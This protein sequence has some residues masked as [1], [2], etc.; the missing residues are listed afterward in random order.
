[1]ATIATN[2]DPQ[3]QSSLSVMQTLVDGYG[4]RDFAVRFWDGTTWSPDSG[5]AASFTLVLNHPGSVRRMFWPPRP[6]TTGQAFLYD[7]FDVEGDMLA[8]AGLCGFLAN[9]KNR[10]SLLQKLRLGWRIWKLPEVIKPRL[11]REAVKLT[12][13]KHSRQRDHQAISYHYDTP[14]EFFENVLDPTMQYTCAVFGSPSEDLETAQRR[15]MDLLCRKLRIQPGERLVDVGCGW[16]GQIM[17]AAKN[18]GAYGIGV[19]LAQRQAE[20]CIRAI[21]QAGLEDRCRIDVCDYRD[22]D[23]SLPIDKIVT[24][25]VAEHFGEENLPLYFQKCWRLLRPGGSL[26]LQQITLAGETGMTVARDFSEHYI[27]PDGELVPLSTLVRLGELTGFEVRDVESL[28]EHYPTTLKAWLRN[29]ESNHDAI[30]RATDEA[31]YRVFRLFFSGACLGFQNNI[32]NLHH[33]L[34]V[35]PDGIRSGY[36]LNRHDWYKGK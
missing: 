22:I 30:V 17:H 11:G 31:T 3:V 19:T 23:E 32:Y 5:Q 35:K 7:D 28:R 2:A 21:R 13:R 33:I 8:F 12:G 27:F 36:P 26:L 1:M 15:K 34:F 18:Y 16:A 9:L 4:P 24:V 6:L 29:L 20:W 25:E 10:L 14:N